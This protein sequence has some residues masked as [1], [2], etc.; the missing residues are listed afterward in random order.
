[1]V[2]ALVVAL[3]GPLPL[4]PNGKLDRKALPVPD[5]AAMTGDARPAN[6]TQARLAA[7]FGEILKLEKVG[8]HDNFFALGGHS[9]A[10]MRLLGRIRAEFGVE[11][12]IRDVFDALTVAGIEGKLKGASTARRPCA[13]R[14]AVRNRSWPPVQRW[15]WDA[16]QRHAGF[17]HALVL[18]SPGGLDP[19][20]LSAA[21]AD[22]A[23][24]HEPL[25]TAFTERDGAL[26][27]R[28]SNPQ[29]SPW[30]TARTWRRASPNWPPDHPRPTTRPRS[31]PTS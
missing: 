30:R 25:R 1:M 2:P 17:D 16:H 23:D 11:L 15:Q 31:A 20:A 9:M 8:V 4:T 7:L 3:D 6:E 14:K 29:S 26:H 21:L 28:P 18:R 5:W 13:R 27:L 22:V 12:S 24:R 10:S 19:D